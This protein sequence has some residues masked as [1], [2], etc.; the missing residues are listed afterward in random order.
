MIFVD[1]EFNENAGR[2]FL[3]YSSF[4]KKK[5]KLDISRM[6]HFYPEIISQLFFTFNFKHSLKNCSIFFHL[7]PF[8][9]LHREMQIIFPR[10][11]FLNLTF[12]SL[13]CIR[14]RRKMFSRTMTRMGISLFKV[15]CD[16]GNIFH[17]FSFVLIES[18]IALKIPIFFF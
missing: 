7:K 18:H 5:S 16:R 14:M 17:L 13:L 3:K 1:I 15:I 9:N 4:R 8:T 11:N 10:Y 2:L 6:Y 12:S